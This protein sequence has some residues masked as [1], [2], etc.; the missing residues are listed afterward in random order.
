[1]N[2][3]PKPLIVVI[4]EILSKLTHAEID[5]L[6]FEH[7]APGDPPQENKV[8]KVLLWFKRVDDDPSID[9]LDFL[10]RIIQNT[11]EYEEDPENIFSLIKSNSK[12][13][14]RLDKM[15][16]KYGFEYQIGGR[17]VNIDA[18]KS[19][20][21][22]LQVTSSYIGSALRV[23]ISYST[24]DKILAGQLKLCLE[25]MGMQV[26]LAHEDLKPSQEWQ[27]TILGNLDSADIFI[28]LI[29]DS[30]QSS[31]WTDQESG[32]AFAKQKVI[33]PIK[34]S[35][36]PYGFLQRFQADAYKPEM[37]FNGMRLVEFL[38]AAKPYL[39]IRVVDSVINHFAVSDFWDVAGRRAKLVKEIETKFGSFNDEQAK[40]LLDVCD[41]NSEIKDSFKAGPYIS[42]WKNK[43]GK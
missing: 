15:L 19:V 42:H 41:S 36:N 12:D 25:D 21:K 7:D 16:N 10:A 43:Y 26:F 8:N 5:Q 23:F 35:A 22:K 11:M 6:F 18:T 4:A 31:K 17:I 13:R 39:K 30:F 1:M 29:T 28:P 24:D 14:E 3:I 32:I 2:S 33:L 40:K 37:G 34:V 27:D 9:S 38:V 20:P